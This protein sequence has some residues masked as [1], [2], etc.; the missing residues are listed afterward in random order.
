MECF[1]NPRRPLCSLSQSIPTPTGKHYFNW[2][3][4]SW[5]PQSHLPATFS[6]QPWQ[7]FGFPHSRRLA[8][9]PLA[10]FL[11]CMA[12]LRPQNEALK[13]EQQA[14]G[15]YFPLAF[16]TLF[17]LWYSCY[18][19]SGSFI[20]TEGRTR[21]TETSLKGREGFGS[22]IRT[23]GRQAVLA[24]WPSGFGADFTPEPS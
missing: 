4:F 9:S 11:P 14:D 13:G 8:S 10:P 7:L 2:S 15:V 21:L 6:I 3:Q 22:R 20:T 24:S 16:L 17:L 5:G 23:E 19:F 18:T 1:Q 12:P